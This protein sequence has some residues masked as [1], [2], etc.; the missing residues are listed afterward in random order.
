MKRCGGPLVDVRSFPTGLWVLS[1]DERLLRRE[2]TARNWGAAM[3]FV[4]A[5]SELA[6]AANHH[7]DVHV[8]NWR[9]VRL[10][11]STHSVGG[12]TKQDVDLAAKIDALDV[13]YSPKWLE[14]VRGAAGKKDDEGDEEAAA[15]DR[16]YYVKGL[17]GDFLEDDDPASLLAKYAGDEGRFENP[18]A[19]DIAR[20][21]DEI[22][23][24]LVDHAGLRGTSV[25]ADLGAGTGL[26]EAGLSKVAAKVVASEL[27]PGFRKI[28]EDRVG[29][30]PNVDV[31]APADERDPGLNPDSVDVCLLCDV[32]H[33][34]VYPK[35]VVRKIRQ[36]LKPFGALV[37]I[38]FHRDPDKI[39]SHDKDWVFSHL[40]ADQ[41][42]YTR[43]IEAC[44]FVQLADV[45]L[46]GLPENY[47]LVFRP[48]PL[49][50][51]QPG[52]GWA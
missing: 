19:R 44:G 35:T 16:E 25:V 2:F 13:D 4:N 1:S 20:A 42:T 45:D 48:R 36:S 38:D 8:T 34:L 29:H 37:V 10:D 24:A 3:R 5:V 17:N 26:L 15:F 22:V 11:L 18:E 6:E 21:K 23:Q 30:L 33:H 39:T 52:A 14:K 31:V 46:P 9:D 7:P 51:S 41:R 32:Y 47:F 12:L 27:S 28:L 50:L 40:R 43:E 49:P